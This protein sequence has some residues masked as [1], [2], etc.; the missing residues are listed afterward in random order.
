MWQPASQLSLDDLRQTEELSADLQLLLPRRFDVHFHPNRFSVQPE[1]H[2]TSQGGKAG[3][4][5]DRENAIG[6][7]LGQNDPKSLSLRGTHKQDLT[8]AD[9]LGL[10]SVPNHERPAAN[11]APGDRFTEPASERILAQYANRNRITGAREC[12]RRPFHELGEVV[13]HR[14]LQLVLFH[15]GTEGSYR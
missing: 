9:L 8:V 2:N 10:G 3:C 14:G 11:G 4:V 5:A 13:Y 1:I 12:L 15:L 7:H 6:F